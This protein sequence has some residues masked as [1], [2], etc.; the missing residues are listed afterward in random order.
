[1]HMESKGQSGI[2]WTSLLFFSLFALALA[3]LLTNWFR[4]SLSLEDILVL[5]PLGIMSIVVVFLHALALYYRRGNI[6]LKWGALL[7]VLIGVGIA[8]LLTKHAHGY[9]FPSWYT[10]DVTR[11][12]TQSLKTEKGEM[13]Y[14]IELKNTFSSSH[15][16]NLVVSLSG[17]EIRIHLP[18]PEGSIRGAAISQNPSDWGTLEPTPS[19]TQ[20]ILHT[21]NYL[22]EARFLV[23][24]PTRSARV[25]AR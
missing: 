9:Y 23:D 4:Y 10:A 16:E 15:E 21:T 25:I 13:T 18:F 11:N 17:Q 1:M 5:L 20:Y 22:K 19:S 7:S 14:Y 6:F 8:L 12:G 24:L 2:L 3:A